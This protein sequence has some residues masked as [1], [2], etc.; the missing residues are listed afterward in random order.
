MSSLRS[1]GYRSPP[2]LPLCQTVQLSVDDR[3]MKLINARILPPPV[4][5]NNSAEINLGRI[6][7]KGKFADPIELT[8]VAFVYFGPPP[9][10]PARPSNQPPPALLP[11]KKELMEKF[12]QAFMKVIG[13]SFEFQL[14]NSSNY[15]DSE[16]I[17]YWTLEECEKRSR[18]NIGE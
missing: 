12:V 13:F 14:N 15:V 10:P 7:L 6:N 2:Q 17:P 4:I 5:N 3:E 11:E 18:S 1:C 16:T 9:P 8:S